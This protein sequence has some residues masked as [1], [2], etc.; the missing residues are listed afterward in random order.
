MTNR[1]VAAIT[2]LIGTTSWQW[3]MAL[4]QASA[5]SDWSA[6]GATAN[7]RAKSKAWRMFF[8]RRLMPKPVLLN[9]WY[10]QNH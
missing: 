7:P 10:P 8:N 3:E 5:F 6:P 9:L 2:G 4:L 1:T